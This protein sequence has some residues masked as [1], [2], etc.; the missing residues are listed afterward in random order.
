MMLQ[1]KQSAIV[2]AST[3]SGKA[4]DKRKAMLEIPE[5]LS[6]LK[7]FEKSVFISSTKKAIR[8]YEE[9]DLLDKVNDLAIMLSKDL[10][11]KVQPDQY[12]KARF[13]DVISKYY[14]DLTLGEI[15]ASFDLSMIGELDLYLPKDRQGQPDKGHYQSFSMDYVTKILNAYRK[16]RSYI[17]TKANGAVPISEKTKDLKNIKKWNMVTFSKLWYKFLLYKYRGRLELSAIDELI[18]Y[19][20]FLKGGIADEVKA[21]DEEKQKAYA[22]I[23]HGQTAQAMNKYELGSIRKKGNKHELVAAI[24]YNISVRKE[25]KR[26]LDYMIKEEIDIC[27]Y[28]I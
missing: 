6:S 16:L 23:V 26:V 18:I 20:L 12:Q 7:S 1:K 27:K 24:G 11:I 3:T 13:F 21:T 25:V 22:E 4:V 14:S 15:K 5:V 9:S 17:M 28:L 19:G 2:L 10:G 8:E